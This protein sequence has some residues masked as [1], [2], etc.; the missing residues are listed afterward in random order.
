MSKVRR[1]RNDIN[2][3]LEVIKKIQDDPKKST[4]DLYDLYLK[5]ADIDKKVSDT[6]DGLKSK[7]KRKG[8]TFRSGW[9]ITSL[10]ST[11]P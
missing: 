10:Q 5:Q 3:K 1:V 2:S 9:E 8:A 7:L 6:L 11:R 4:D